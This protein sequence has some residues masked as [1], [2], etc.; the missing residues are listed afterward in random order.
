MGREVRRVPKDWQHPQHEGGKYI[1]LMDNFHKRL[2]EWNEGNE[3]WAKGFRDDFNGGWKPREDDEKNM[4]YEE[5][6]GPRPEA[7]EY[8][9]DWPESERTHIQMY[10]DCSE[11]TPISPVMEKPEELARWLADN[12]ASAFGSMTASYEQW[13]ATIKRGFAFSMVI[14]DNKIRSGVDAIAEWDEAP[15]A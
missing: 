10:E 7:D 5:W 4:T 13:L 15:H 2:S 11:G 14:E 12:N 6:T 9:P 3:M 1:P 8:M